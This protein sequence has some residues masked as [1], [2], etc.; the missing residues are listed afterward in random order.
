M[1]SRSRRLTLFAA[2]GLLP[3]AISG[4]AVAAG[5]S[6]QV[7]HGKPSV[8]SAAQVRHLSASATHRSIII[9]KNQ[10]TNLPAKGGTAGLRARAAKAD[11]AAVRS[12]LARVHAT[13]I[14]SFHIVNAIAAT[15]SAAE[16]RRLGANPAVRAVVPDVLRHFSSLGS[17]PG[18]ALPAMPARHRGRTDS[19]SVGAQPICPSN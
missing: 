16:A 17:G 8:L 15:I 2:A 11:Q 9:F 7:F 5:S 6:H 13:H 10:L 12:E 4:T 3:V 19:P 18:P 1:R 14:T